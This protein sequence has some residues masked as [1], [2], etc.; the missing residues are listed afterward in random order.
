MRRHHVVLAA[1]LVLAAALSGCAKKTETASENNADS[2]LATNP[3]EQPQGNLT[4]QTGFQPDQQTPPAPAPSEAAPPAKTHTSSPSHP[5]AT[6][7][8][9]A[10]PKGI[11]LAAGTPLDIAVN[12]AITTEHAQAG[13]AWQGVVKENVIVGN[14]VVIP[15]GSVVQGVINASQPAA[16]GT[17]ASLTLA[18]KSITVNGTEHPVHASAESIVAGSTRARN[19]GAVA[20]GAAAGALIG[21]AIGGGKGAVIGGLLGAGAGTAGAAASKGYQ[22]TVKEGAVITFSVDEAVLVKS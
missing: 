11:T 13:D 4:P 19:V 10:A 7:H 15:A 22:V 8:E 16:K 2:L 9:P 14:I 5:K 18:V 3:V 20:G 17:R 1:G 12:T 6:S 21:S